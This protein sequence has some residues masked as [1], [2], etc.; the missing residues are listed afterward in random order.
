MPGPEL[1]PI[2]HATPVKLASALFAAE[3][4]CVIGTF[5]LADIKFHFGHLAAFPEG[6]ERNGMSSTVRAM[7]GHHG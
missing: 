4:C 2:L 6:A 7:D 5:L 3:V 1:E